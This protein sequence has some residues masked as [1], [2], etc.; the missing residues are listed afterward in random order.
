M[1][2]RGKVYKNP[3]DSRKGKKS[4]QP[5]SEANLSI[6]GDPKSKKKEKVEEHRKQYLTGG[7]E[8]NMRGGNGE[9]RKK[10]GE[11]SA[12]GSLWRPLEREE[13][14]VSG[15]SQF[16]CRLFSHKGD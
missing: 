12:G 10:G 4:D 7:T 2:N 8:K 5:S 6:N 15:C 3:L 11:N 16:N 13:C 14:C 1:K 9:M